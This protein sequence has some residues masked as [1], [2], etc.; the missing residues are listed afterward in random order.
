MTMFGGRPGL[1]AAMLAARSRR[2]ASRFSEQIQQ[3][4]RAT[5]PPPVTMVSLASAAFATA[6][7]RM[8]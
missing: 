2:R 6:M 1:G 4:G 8:S 3:H 7:K 5:R